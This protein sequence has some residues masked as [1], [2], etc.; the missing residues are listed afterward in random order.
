MNTGYTVY[1]VI[2]EALV[3]TICGQLQIASIPFSAS[4]PFRGYN[5]QI[6][7]KSITHVIYL[8]LKVNGHAEQTCFMLIVSL[9]N[10][11]IIIDKS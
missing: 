8:T 11:R 4:R 9:N 5:G 1:T 6:A 7:P 10:H 2:D 3:E